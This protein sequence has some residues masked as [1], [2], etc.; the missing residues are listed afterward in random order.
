LQYN[1]DVIRM[2]LVVC[3][4][5]LNY[6]LFP[7]RGESLEHWDVKL[8]K[9]IIQLPVYQNLAQIYKFRKQWD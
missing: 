9:K 1:E 8:Q 5:N 4:I 6:A 3:I 2:S 7:F